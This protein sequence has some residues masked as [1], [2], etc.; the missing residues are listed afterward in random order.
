ML[1]LYT[2]IDLRDP[3]ILIKHFFPCNIASN[4]IICE[5]QFGN[6][7][8][9]RTPITK[10]EAAKWEFSMQRWVDLSDLGRGMT[11]FNQDRY[12]CSAN[13]I[14]VGI[15]LVRSPPYPG[16][17]VYTH[18]KVF[19]SK[20][21]P[22]YT[23]LMEHEFHYGIFPHQNSW[24]DAHIPE[25]GR[26]FGFPCYII[27]NGEGTQQNPEEEIS[28]TNIHSLKMLTK[29]LPKIVSNQKNVIITAIKPGEWMKQ[30]HNLRKMQKNANYDFILMEDEKDWKWD[31]QHII[32]RCFEAEGKK[33][34]FIL[35][36]SSFSQKFQMKLIEELDLLE[37]V[38][39]PDEEIKNEENKIF[40][41]INPY[42]IK[43]IRI[44]FKVG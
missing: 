25:K 4:E 35:S 22:K 23:D 15:T 12:G 1:H 44:Q 21:I 34:D 32:I 11:F 38:I 37:R 27:K 20:K 41:E 13:Q 2:Q 17:K 16:D 28:K 3:K 40:L 18:Q 39:N 42:E 14:G 36:F 31:N 19:A 10:M 9:K 5:T 43:T 6:V 33:C 30:N 8:R 7:T 29:L 24:K 26:S